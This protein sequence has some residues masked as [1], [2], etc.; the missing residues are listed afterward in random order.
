MGNGHKGILLCE[1]TDTTENITFLQLRWR[2]VKI[3]WIGYCSKSIK[4]SI[5][6]DDCCEYSFSYKFEIGKIDSV[7]ISL[8]IH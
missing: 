1:Q 8:K 7:C 5:N 4:A 3:K 6:A 2:V